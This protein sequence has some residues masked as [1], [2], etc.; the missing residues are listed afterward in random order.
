MRS[1]TIISCLVLGIKVYFAMYGVFLNIYFITISLSLG[2]LFATCWARECAGQERV[3]KG[4][5]QGGRGAEQDDPHRGAADG[6]PLA[7]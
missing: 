7:R 5:E 1:F 2:R 6:R 4:K 3:K